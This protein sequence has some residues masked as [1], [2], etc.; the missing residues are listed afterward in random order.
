MLRFSATVTLDEAVFKFTNKHVM[1]ISPTG[2]NVTDS[3]VQIQGM[4][5]ERAADCSDSD[6]VC[7]SATSEL[8]KADSTGGSGD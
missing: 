1:A 8:N 4:F 7:T 3:Y 5:A 6:V 2:Q